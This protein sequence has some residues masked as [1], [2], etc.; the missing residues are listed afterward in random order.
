VRQSQLN[1]NFG[2]YEVIPGIYQVRGFDLANI[3]FIKGNTGWIVFDPMS[4]A[5]TA[6]AAKELVDKHLGERPVVAVVHSH[7]HGDHWGGVRGIVDEAE[8]RRTFMPEP[9]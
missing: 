6:R 4:A 8:L 5:E 9:P 3:T 2:L 7:N 1:M